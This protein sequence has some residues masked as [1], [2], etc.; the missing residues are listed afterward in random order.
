MERWRP[1]EIMGEDGNKDRGK[2]KGRETW[3]EEKLSTRVEMGYNWK[4]KRTRVYKGGS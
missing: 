4:R 2:K 1:R 3:K